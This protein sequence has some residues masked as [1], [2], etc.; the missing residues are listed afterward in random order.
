MAGPISGIDWASKIPVGGTHT[1]TSAEASANAVVIDTGKA[2]AVGFIVQIYASGALASS[3][4]A[5]SIASGVLT[6][7]DGSSYNVT[8]GH[9][10]N[11]IVF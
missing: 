11:W 7:A 5:A 9:V 8:N 2:D 3:N 10:I 1:T 6:V 4:V